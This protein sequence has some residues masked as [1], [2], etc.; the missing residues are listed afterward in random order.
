VQEAD[1]TAAQYADYRESL[2]EAL[3]TVPGVHVHRPAAAPFL[4]LR[5]EN[6]DRVREDLRARGI[7]VRR[8]DTFPGLDT[9]YVRVAVRSPEQNAK[10]VEALRELLGARRGSTRT[11]V[12]V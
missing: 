7:A 1:R 3:A 4:L 8:G 2:A 11:G 10:L 6:G 12:A 5:V 9:E